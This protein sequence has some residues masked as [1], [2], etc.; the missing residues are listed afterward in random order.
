MRQ[1]R[2]VKGITIFLSILVIGALIYI[3]IKYYDELSSFPWELNFY[4][5]L[6]LLI[7]HTIAMAPTFL[8]WHLMV[9]KIGQFNN[10]KAN[11]KYYYL[12]ALAKRLPTSIPYIGGRL[13]LYNRDGIS[14]AAILNCSILE[15]LLFSI[16][17][18]IAYL[19]LHPLY[20]SSKDEISLLVAIIG[21]VF[22]VV[23][24]LWPRLLLQVTNWFLHR[25]NKQPLT[26]FPDRKDLVLW[27]SIYIIPWFI[28]GYAFYLVPKA[29][30]DLI[31]IDFIDAYKISTISTLASQLYIILPGGLAIREFTASVL[32]TQF[33]TVPIAVVI[34][35]VFR[36][37]Q[38]IN[39]I[40]MAVVFA[41]IT[42]RNI[43]AQ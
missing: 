34:S 23:I 5:I 14:N 20:K 16:G 19:L 38:T 11:L 13:Y 7:V 42:Q 39:E 9:S 24:F 32:L 2:Q 17:G 8:A 10:I 33:T 6:L 35:I 36:I 30:S 41:L 26:S 27:I 21:V 28:S 29:L 1:Q 25:F 31:S 22:T 37:T 12:S 3:L 4:L 43:E 40:I 15:T 18:I